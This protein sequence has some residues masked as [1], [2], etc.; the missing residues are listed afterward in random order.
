MPSKKE[1]RSMSCS[2]TYTPTIGHSMP[3]TPSI[4]SV[5]NYPE[6]KYHAELP[7]VLGGADD[8]RPVSMVPSRGDK[9]S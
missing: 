9:S 2:I 3:L 7:D 5:T 8:D 6:Y 4:F 1:N